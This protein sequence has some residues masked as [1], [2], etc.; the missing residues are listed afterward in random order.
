VR[1]S[2]M[3]DSHT[4]L[5]PPAWRSLV[6]VTGPG[7]ILGALTR[8]SRLGLRHVRAWVPVRYAIG[9]GIC[10]GVRLRFGIIFAAARS[11]GE[12]RQSVRPR[13]SEG[14]L[15]RKPQCSPPKLTF[16]QTE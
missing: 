2:E 5:K 12:P 11:P 7:P 9:E 6:V 8:P 3:T 4:E 15:A 14:L 1:D 10:A 13:R 16:A